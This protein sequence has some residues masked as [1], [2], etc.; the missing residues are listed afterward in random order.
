MPQKNPWYL[1]T[2]F[3]C[4]LFALWYF[5]IPPVIGIVPVS[6]THLYIRMHAI[7]FNGLG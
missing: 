5:F 7:L 1:S 2:L 6:Y 3:I 4:L